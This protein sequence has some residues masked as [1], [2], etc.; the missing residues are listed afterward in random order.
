MY[1]IFVSNGFKLDCVFNSVVIDSFGIWRA[2]RLHNCWRGIGWLRLGQPFERKPQCACHVDWS[3]GR[4]LES[5]DPYTRRLYQNH[6]RSKGELDV[7]HCA[8]C[9]HGGSKN[10]D[11]AGQSSGRVFCNQRDALCARSSGR[12]WRLGGAGQRWLVLFGRFALLQ[13]IRKLPNCIF[14]GARRHAVSRR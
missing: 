4:G 5:A 11:A 3:W 6:G 9:T 7:R 13:E 10:C 8:R 12:L 1:R 14:A 2:N